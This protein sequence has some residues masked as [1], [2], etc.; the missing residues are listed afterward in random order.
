MRSAGLEV[1]EHRGA[2][3]ER[4]RRPEHAVYDVQFRVGLPDDHAPGL[5]SIVEAGEPLGV[6]SCVVDVDGRRRRGL[7]GRVTGDRRRG[8]AEFGSPLVGELLD[9]ALV[10]VTRFKTNAE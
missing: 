2:D 1:Q 9:C 8:R 3:D 10:L 6:G 7:D 5:G 4:Q